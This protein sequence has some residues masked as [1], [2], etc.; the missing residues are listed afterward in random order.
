MSN[1]N[2]TG[3]SW[4]SDEDAYFLRDDEAMGLCDCEQYSLFRRWPCYARVIV[5]HGPFD[6][7]MEQVHEHVEQ[8]R[9]DR[10]CEH[11]TVFCTESL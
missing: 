3:L 9:S 8:D 6:W 5:L 1:Q 7:A 2:N 10:C 4:I 11:E